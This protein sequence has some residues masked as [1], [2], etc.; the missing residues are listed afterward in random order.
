MSDELNNGQTPGQAPGSDPGAQWAQGASGPDP[1]AQWASGPQGPQEAQT[2]PPSYE[3]PYEQPGQNYG[4]P[5]YAGGPEKMTGI[6]DAYK[7]YWKNYVNFRDR[8]SRAGFWWV[9]LINCIIGAILSAAFLGPA[10]AAMAVAITNPAYATTAIMS[11]L[12]GS[13][14]ICNLWSLAN[15][16][17]SLSI[18]VRRLHDTGKR[19]VYILLPFAGILLSLLLSLFLTSVTSTLLITLLMSILTIVCSIVFIVFLAKATKYPPENRF[20]D[21]PKQG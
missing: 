10:F 5:Y 21:L 7:L 19:W 8:T 16:L 20:Y 2:P 4:N 11:S 13:A 15:L 17:P 6:L 14:I 12:A 1:G 18:T 3:S 9:Q